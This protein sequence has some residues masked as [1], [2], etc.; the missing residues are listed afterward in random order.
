MSVNLYLTNMLLDAI[1][2]IPP[3][4]SF[5]TKLLFPN[6]DFSHTKEVF[7]DVFQGKRRVA[8]IVHPDLP[9]KFIERIGYKTNKITPPYVHTLHVA[10]ASEV[11]ESRP[12]GETP[13][14]GMPRSLRERAMDLFVQD[15]KEFQ[16]MLT[17]RKEIMASQIAATGIVACPGAEGYGPS[18]FSLDYDIPEEFRPT[19]DAADLF[20][21]ETSDPFK[22]LREFRRLGAQ[23]GYSYDTVIFGWAAWDAFIS[24]ETVKDYL[25][26]LNINLGQI[27]PGD[28]TA[29]VTKMGRVEGF[30]LY[31]YDEYYLDDWTDPANPTEEPMVTPHSIIMCVNKS[32]NSVLHGAI[33]DFKV[34]GRPDIEFFP[35]VLIMDNPSRMFLECQ[36][37][38]L[39]VPKDSLSILR[40]IVCEDPEGE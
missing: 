3:A 2:N 12:F 18:G 34:D 28:M 39:L 5:L 8:P 15:L 36:S 33:L 7:I 38:P 6:T 40:A 35:K 24:N 11:F 20:D 1:S 19:L 37:A 13:F 22:K 27:Q 9:G 32:R 23:S 26:K 25:N 30:D 16:D 4:H 14:A 21:A 29:G 31:T 17:R 10:K